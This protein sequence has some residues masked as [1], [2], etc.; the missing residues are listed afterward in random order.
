VGSSSAYA[1][2]VLSCREA[3]ASRARRLRVCL[4]DLLPTVPYYTGHLCAALH[5]QSGIEVSLCVTTYSHDRTFFQRTG[6]HRR[7]GLLDFAGHLPASLKSLRRAGKL[8][9]YIFN[10]IRL[11]VHFMFSPPDVVHVEFVPLM[12]Y[13]LPFERWFLKL[14]RLFGSKLVYTMHN[15]LPHDSHQRHRRAYAKIYRLADRI[16]CHDE[17]AKNRLIAEFT[18]ENDRI[19]IIPHGELFSD[20]T[21]ADPSSTPL[22]KTKSKELVVL[23]QGIIRPYKGIPFLL[24][25]WKVALQAGLQAS[26]WIVGT[27]E[28]SILRQIEQEAVALD[29]GSSVHFDFRFVS[30]EELSRYYQSADILV[31]PYSDITTSGA[32]MTGIGYGKAIVATNLTAFEQMLQHEHNALL[33]PYGDVA[34]WASALIRVAS[35]SHLRARLVQGLQDTQALTPTWSEIASETCHL[36]EQLVPSSRRETHIAQD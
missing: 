27:G 26:L 15:V 3:T 28:E 21:Q 2:S 20:K 10:L 5:K 29:L 17:Q 19:S 30:V 35:D 1:N 7:R 32:L 25:A 36:Y 16:I 11:S 33:A 22:P 34:E 13:S 8:V 23:C 31:Y 4:L 18:V 6:L 24:H 9:E 12:N 14:A